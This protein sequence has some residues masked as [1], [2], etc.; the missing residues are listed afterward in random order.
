MRSSSK[1]KL[2]CTLDIMKKTDEFH[3]LN[4]RQIAQKLS[5]LG[6]TA[7][8]K[9]IARDLAYL[10]EAGFSILRCDEYSKGYYMND[11]LFEDYELKLLCD[12]VASTPF[13]TLRDTQTLMKKIVTLATPEG[14][15]ML[16]ASVYLEEGAKSRDT[17]N[18]RK[19]DVVLRAVKSKR[20]LSFQYTKD[21]QPGTPTLARHGYRYV[22]SPY[23][24]ALHKGLY[25]L[26][27]NTETNPHLTHFRLDRM[28]SLHLLDEPRRPPA[29]V[30]EHGDH[31][32]L[33]KYLRG[34]IGMWTGER[35]TVTLM[36]SGMTTNAV[37]QAL[38]N[39]AVRIHQD[40]DTITAFVEVSESPGLNP[41]FASLGP[42]MQVVAPDN[43]RRAFYGYLCRIGRLYEQKE[44]DRT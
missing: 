36:F 44:E 7:E 43:V 14:E 21:E 24:L 1:L 42:K 26:I 18:K 30:L 35:V 8:R 20:K 6:I 28:I 9:S 32:S 11:H 25:Y 13:L 27:G 38:N 5:A 39:R 37:R 2:L 23:Y 33:E 34:A 15:A 12:A 31:F 10:N 16:K 3:P 40:E 22:V 4:T 29:D 41:W 19:M 17:A